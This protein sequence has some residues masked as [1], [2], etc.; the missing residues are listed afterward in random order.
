MSGTRCLSL[1]LAAAASSCAAPPVR[2]PVIQPPAVTY[3]MKLAAILRLEDRRVL[4]EAAAEPGPTLAADAPS[5]LTV[6]VA[7]PEG[8]VR[9]RAALAIGRVGLRDGVA[10][11]VTT[12]SD[13]EPEVRQMAAFA[14]GLLGDRQA[15]GP[16]RAALRDPA[17]LVRGR[18][19]EALGAVG[20]AEAAPAIAAMVAAEAASGG[21]SRLGPD[22]SDHLASPTAEPFRLGVNALV[23]LKAAGS[24]SAVVLDDAGQP[25]VHWWPVAWALQRLPETRAL[26]ALLTF[27]HSQGP[28]CRSLAARGLGALKDPA[29]I[30]ALLPMVQRWAADVRLAVV[31]VRALA[32]IGDRRAGPALLAVLRAKDLEPVLKAEIVAALGAVS[33]EQ[34][35]E[36]LLDLLSDRSP[37][38]RIAALQSLRALDAQNFVA[39]LSGLDPDRD[40]RVRAAIASS[41]GTL[42]A[43]TSTPR[44]R[45]ALSDPDAR[46]IPAVLAALVR[47]RAPGTEGVLLSRLGDDD[48]IVRAAAATG[49]GDLRPDGA[50]PRL[51]DAYRSA[52]ADPMHA[53]RAA[54]LDAIARYGPEAALPVLKQA[55]ADPDWAVRLRAARLLT[56]LAPATDWAAAIRPAPTRRD[57]AWYATPE[58]VSPA[59]SPHLF[60]ETTRGTIEIELAVLDAPLTAASIGALTRGGFYDGLTFHR[61]VPDFVI[62][63][64]DPRGDGEGG[65]AFTIRDEISDRPFL[66][67]AV[68]IALDGADTGGS[69]FFITL[70]P[71]PHLDGRYTI[72]G[73]VVAGMDV[74]ARIQ[75]GDAIARMRVWDGKTMSGDR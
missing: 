60:I 15:S 14:L 17:P 53:A 66:A 72:V 36:A 16:L 42:D 54:A 18:A 61:V 39:V 21:V 23:R 55:L 74:A 26:P 62:Q 28:L 47:L 33:A 20:D 30:E 46:V 4:R 7:D 52:L 12:L 70:S 69:Q 29:A 9:R 11:L 51:A 35:D 22:E 44:L 68:G 67:G 2:P 37:P 1:L 10:P 57:A 75:Q 40:W 43:E 34:A 32:Q 38:V 50:A 59:V 5:D 6:L 45:E 3:E 31:A 65:A 73:Q 71:Q 27:A 58:L 63:A 19:A 64:G 41:M 56:T 13:A 24:L 8:R 49:L 25:V 48:P